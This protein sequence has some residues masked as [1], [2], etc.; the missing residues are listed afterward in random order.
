MPAGSISSEA[1]KVTG[2]AV[3]TQGGT[4]VL[5]LHQKVVPSV[6]QKAG[7]VKFID[8]LGA[9]PSSAVLVGHNSH[10]FD[11]PVLLNALT[12][13]GL[14]EQFAQGTDGFADSLS[15]FKSM[16]AGPDGYALGKLYRHHFGEDFAAHDAG[17]DVAAL[18]RL[19]QKTGADVHA[20]A[21]TCASAVECLRFSNN[22][23]SRLDSFS[24]LISAK[25][26]S[27]VMAKKAASSGLSLRHVELAFQRSNEVGIAALFKEKSKTNSSRVTSSKK[28]IA[29]VNKYFTSVST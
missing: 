26:L 19:L 29:A 15:I 3:S 5:T 4:Q 1:S 24:P 7:L 25:V 21:F 13:H 10:S 23:S 9:L 6:T 12:Q 11:I 16:S 22:S 17:A 27:K 8:W 28:I 20:A 18:A 14:L 2:L